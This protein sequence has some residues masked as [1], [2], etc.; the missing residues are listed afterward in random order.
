VNQ[1][2]GALLG[3]V[4]D[5]VLERAFEYW[6]NVDAD[7]GKRI[8]EKVRAGSAKEPVSGMSEA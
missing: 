1:I 6:K 3:G 8:E 7:F 5:D 2:S 4:G